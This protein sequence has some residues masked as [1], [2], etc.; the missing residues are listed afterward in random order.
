LTTRSPGKEAGL[1]LSDSHLLFNPHD[2]GQILVIEPR[3]PFLSHE[4]PVHCQN[5]N[6]TGRQDGEKLFGQAF[7]LG[8]IRI[9]TLALLGENRPNDWNG[10]IT[11]DNGMDDSTEALESCGVAAYRSFE[12]LV[13]FGI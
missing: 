3:K 6:V 9:S 1:V 7:P 8:G 2:I 5:F 11:N 4:L 12:G 10:N 13:D